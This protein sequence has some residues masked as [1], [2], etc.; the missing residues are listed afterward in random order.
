[1]KQPD[2]LFLLLIF[3]YFLLPDPDRPQYDKGDMAPGT[4][5]RV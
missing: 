1:M 5:L 2:H 3:F 4:N